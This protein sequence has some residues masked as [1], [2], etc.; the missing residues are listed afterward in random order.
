MTRS[1]SRSGG[2]VVLWAGGLKMGQVIG[3]TDAHA[4]YPAERP[5]SPLD[6]LAT[7]YHVVGVD[8]N[9]IFYNNAQRPNLILPGGQPIP[10]LIG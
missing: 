9:H 7:M 2:A 10:E 1:S 3:K 6:V 5:L 8:P 4:E